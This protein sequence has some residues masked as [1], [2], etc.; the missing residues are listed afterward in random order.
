MKENLDEPVLPDSYQ[1]H[2]G[3][4]YVCDGTITISPVQ[5]FVSGLKRRLGVNE[6]RRCD[7]MGRGLIG[8]CL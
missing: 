5:G 7:V 8:G 4:F 3:F 2:F 6:V 1:V